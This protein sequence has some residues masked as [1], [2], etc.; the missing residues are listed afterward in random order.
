MIHSP[1]L[2]VYFEQLRKRPLLTREEE[3]ELGVKVQK[4]SV[5][6]RN[7]MIESNLRLVVSI[8]KRFQGKGI[9]FEDLIAEGNVG[10]IR[11]V[12]RFD[13]G[14]G[15]AFSTYA[16]WWIRQSIFRAFE[17]LPR[18]IRLPGHIAE[19][20]RKI[21]ATTAALYDQLGREPTDEEIADAAE[22]SLKKIEELRTV[23]Q[24]L[25]S[26]DTPIGDGSEARTLADVLPDAD[27]IS[28]D[29]SLEKADMLSHLREV[30]PLLPDRERYIII[31]RF[32]LDGTSPQTLEEIGFQLR[33]TRERTRQLQV[34]ALTL[35]KQ[36]LRRLERNRGVQRTALSPKENRT[37]KW[38]EML[39]AA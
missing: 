17:K 22:I 8:A 18:A 1:A 29:E 19:S 5:E 35:L 28:P 15:V 13:P 6:A 27:Y 9:S 33:V 16:T 4:G 32:G 39:P 7:I 23:N 10:L 34:S 3:G 30:V 37:F 2:D 25:V 21:H 36:A 11:A 31:K 12:E 24:P 26:M 14:V 38:S 20:L